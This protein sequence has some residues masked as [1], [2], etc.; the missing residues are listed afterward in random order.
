[1]RRSQRRT[2]ANLKKYK[3]YGF[4]GIQKKLYERQLPK[5]LVEKTMRGFSVDDELAVARRFLTR[6]FG[7][8]GQD[9]ARLQRMLQN[10]GFRGE[11]IFKVVKGAKAAAG[12]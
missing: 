11:V 7:E 6:Q 3:S 9:P 4:Y 12:D 5:P 1:M 10:R 2:L 8:R